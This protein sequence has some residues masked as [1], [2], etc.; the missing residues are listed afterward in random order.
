M[1][2]LQILDE[3]ISVPF[4]CHLVILSETGA[5]GIIGMEKK[6]ET[7]VLESEVQQRQT[8][9]LL[10][11]ILLFYESRILEITFIVKIILDK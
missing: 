2:K 3:A 1:L 11:R 5:V 4:T 8:G 7:R 10:K 9:K 6:G